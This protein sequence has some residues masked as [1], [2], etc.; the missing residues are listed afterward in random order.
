MTAWECCTRAISAYRQFTPNSIQVGIEEASQAITIAPDYGLAHGL[1]A[2]AL[3]VACSYFS[4]GEPDP[5]IRHHIDRA[6]ALDPDNASVLAFVCEA[7]VKIELPDEGLRHGKRAIRLS[8]RAAYA[9]F[10]CGV[11]CVKLNRPEEALRHFAHFQRI[12]P[13]SHLAYQVFAWI[14]GAHVLNHDL[15]AAEMAFDRSL[16][17]EPNSSF[18]WLHK[19]I[20]ASLQHRPDEAQKMMI[21]AR[22]LEPAATLALWE[23]RLKRWSPAGSVLHETL[24][25]LA[26]LWAKTERSI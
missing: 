2:A 12:E 10:Q 24:D 21:T 3:S 11:T 7:L 5:Q 25:Q 22:Q 9:H 14:G 1:L 6:L 23:L 18:V 8:P 26:R 17:L 19:A 15:A 20:I 16:E 13:E 4:F